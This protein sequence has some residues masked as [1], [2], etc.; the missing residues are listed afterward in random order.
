MCRPTAVAAAAGEAGAATEPCSASGSARPAFYTRAGPA[1][2]GSPGAAVAAALPLQAAPAAAKAAGGSGAV[3]AARRRQQRLEQLSRPRHLTPRH[4]HHQRGAGPAFCPAD[5]LPAPAAPEQGISA[6]HAEP[7]STKTA[8]SSRRATGT[9]DSRGI[10]TWRPAQQQATSG[11]SSRLT[12]A[13]AGAGSTKQWPQRLA[14]ELSAAELQRATGAYSEERF[15]QR[16]GQLS[17]TLAA[18]Q[19]HRRQVSDATAAGEM[20]ACA[21]RA[22]TPA[23]ALPAL[24]PLPTIADARKQ[25][26]R[27]SLSG[28]SPELLAPRHFELQSCAI[29]LPFCTVLPLLPAREPQG[30]VKAQQDHSRRQP[31]PPHPANKPD[32][33]RGRIAPV[34]CPPSCP[35]RQPAYCLSSPQSTAP[36]SCS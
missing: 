23:A 16:M 5:A 10:A 35:P 8:R 12:A 27:P 22:S 30:T 19:A 3:S 9:A 28:A 1:A 18:R 14:S 29:C 21:C 24:P 32:E 15:Q 17:A 13:A 36:T 6:R 25:Q 33:L 20:Y 11:P 4:H 34:R 31:S 7:G 2:P 26:Q